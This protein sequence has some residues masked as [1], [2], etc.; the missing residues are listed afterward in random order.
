ME[1][2][3]SK[4]NYYYVMDFLGRG[5]FGKVVKGRMGNSGE[6]VAIKIQRNDDD[7]SHGIWHEIKMLNALKKVDSD[8]WNFIRFYE[9][10][11]DSNKFYLVFELLEQS[12]YDYQKQNSFTPLPINHIRTITTQ[13]LIALSKLQE[14]SIMHTDLKPENIM[15]VNQ[16]KYPFKIKLIDFGNACISQDAN[17]FKQ[18]YMQTRYYRS[19]EILLGLPFS[20]KIDM[21]SL[22]CII[23]ELHLGLPL[24]PGAHEYYQICYIYDTHGMPKS[25][26]LSA[27]G[28]T[29]NFFKKII[30]NNI[31][32]KW[33]LKSEEE[34]WFETKIIPQE[35]RKYVLTSL[36][37]LK[38]INAP[39]YS[40]NDFMAEYNDL[41]NMVSLIKR[42][43]T[44]DSH[45]RISPDL[46]I[47][48]PFISVREMKTEYGKTFQNL[49]EKEKA[50]NQKF[51]ILP[52]YQA[53]MSSLKIDIDQM[54]NVYIKEP[55]EVKINIWEEETE[56]DI[57]QLKSSL[58]ISAAHQDCNII[59]P[60]SNATRSYHN[61]RDDPGMVYAEQHSKVHHKPSDSKQ[62]DEETC[63]YRS[64][65]VLDRIRL[66][67]RHLTHR[68]L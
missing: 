26:L 67:F 14:L 8:K 37:Q 62:F 5:A 11:Y 20:S 46:A 49:I 24:Y 58:E 16:A 43:L 21:W 48:H 10:L 40:D 13:V 19:P 63:S 34:Y 68:I 4:T 57:K 32:S 33:S 17:Y 42:M 15:L 64:V 51:N 23:G 39:S 30:D 31:G 59:I 6:H 12:L 36:N 61:S 50:Q 44:W 18:P 65:S 27:G 35:T 52:G 54:V 3:Q 38:M 41:E 56:M 60:D 1:L 9:Y 7:R 66:C 2:L 22:G 28:K 53:H 45:E 55:R 29:L 25:Q 47:R